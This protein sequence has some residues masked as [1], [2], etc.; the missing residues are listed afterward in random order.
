MC[1]LATENKGF[2]N[3]SLDKFMELH[4]PKGL[5][6]LPCVPFDFKRLTLCFA[7]GKFPKKNVPATDRD[8][9]SYKDKYSRKYDFVK[10][11]FVEFVS[12]SNGTG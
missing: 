5:A 4:I 9:L 11:N 2:N 3:K 10:Q 7:A 6:R 12:R 1:N 8:A